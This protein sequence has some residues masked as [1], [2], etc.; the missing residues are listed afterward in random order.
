MTN[1]QQGVWHVRES[2]GKVAATLH[3]Q[4]WL[5]H[6]NYLDYG[7]PAESIDFSDLCH[8]LGAEISPARIERLTK[9]ANDHMGRKPSQAKRADYIVYTLEADGSIRQ[10]ARVWT[11]IVRQ[12]HPEA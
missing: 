3:R 5:K 9:A 6:L 7:S 1:T 12:G 8:I 2:D 10:N 4:D 11:E